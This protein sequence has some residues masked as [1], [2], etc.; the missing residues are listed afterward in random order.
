MT[1]SKWKG[2]YS[3]NPINLNNL[4]ELKKNYNNLIVPR[5]CKIN[6][7]FIGLT[8]KVHN[9]KNYTEITVTN[10]MIGHKFGEFSLTRSRFVFK[11]KKLKK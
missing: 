9:G 5:N 4:N 10:E 11:K 1:R 6:P 8:F 7:K 3:T 2:P